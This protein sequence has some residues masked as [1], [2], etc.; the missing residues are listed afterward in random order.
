MPK[1][2]S[3]PKTEPHIPRP[4]NRWILYR[5][6]KV[7]EI[8][9]PLGQ[10]RRQQS[11]ISKI[12]AGMWAREPFDIKQVYE[13]K[14]AEAKAD[15][16]R[17]HPKYQYMPQTKEVKKQKQKLRREELARERAAAKQSQVRPAPYTTTPHRHLHT[18][19]S[20]AA[21]DERYATYGPSG[22]SPPLSAAST[23]ERVHSPPARSPT[24]RASPVAS[25][26]QLPSL[27]IPE[28]AFSAPA[29]VPPPSVRTPISKPPSAQGSSATAASRFASAW[30]SPLSQ[31]SSE[32]TRVG[33]DQDAAPTQPQ[34]LSIPESSQDMVRARAIRFARR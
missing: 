28:S 25:T 23:P 21:V 9:P 32:E 34:S 15:H 3:S 31:A 4:P 10:P 22:P 7:K 8:E 11:E 17:K 2:K 18:E 12:I 30:Q 19:I 33:E 20:P 29:S 24:S 6:D 1:D 16:A 26:S 5:A 27:R 13:Q 14:A